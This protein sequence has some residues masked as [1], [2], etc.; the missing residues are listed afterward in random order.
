MI[1][2]LWGQPDV[3]GTF[4]EGSEGGNGAGSGHFCIRG[5]L[6]LSVQGLQVSSIWCDIHLNLCFPKLT[7]SFKSQCFV[8]NPV[9]QA[10]FVVNSVSRADGFC[11]LNLVVML[12]FSV[13][14][15]YKNGSQTT[16]LVSPFSGANSSTVAEFHLTCDPTWDSCPCLPLTQ[17]VHCFLQAPAGAAAAQIPKGIFW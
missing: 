2:V 3:L 8:R 14:V 7:G 5:L 4:R 11:F 15:L 12:L 1:V 10:F 16:L 13:E 6:A 17:T 9:L